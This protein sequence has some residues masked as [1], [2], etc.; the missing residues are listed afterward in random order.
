M[1]PITN[2]RPTMDHLIDQ[3]RFDRIADRRLRVVFAVLLL[4]ITI[5]DIVFGAAFFM[6]LGFGVGGFALSDKALGI[7]A[8]SV[9]GRTIGI[10]VLIVRNL[11][12]RKKQ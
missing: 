3:D 12:P 7:Y 5:L 10:L 2:T 1:K 6:L 9:F 8:T 4:G 11:F